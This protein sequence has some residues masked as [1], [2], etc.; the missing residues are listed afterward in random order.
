MFHG[1]FTEQ[2][3]KFSPAIHGLAIQNYTKHE[4]STATAS[5]EFILNY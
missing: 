2:V 3:L 4:D 5:L 1:R